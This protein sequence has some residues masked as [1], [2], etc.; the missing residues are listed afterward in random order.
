MRVLR[1][2]GIVHLDGRRQ[3]A[4]TAHFINTFFDICLKAAPASELK[5]QPEHP[6]V[7]YVHRARCAV[8]SSFRVCHTKHFSENPSAP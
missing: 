4:L 1:A 7:E 6:E 8:K 5:S 3:V 2:L